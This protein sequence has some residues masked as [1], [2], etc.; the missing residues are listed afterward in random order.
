MTI[1][2]FIVFFLSGAAALV[3]QLVWQRA[4]FGI[5]GLD[6]A[7]V[8]VVVT[9]FMLG[10]GIGSLVGGALSHRHPKLTLPLFAC[11]ELGIGL[12]GFVS[13]P[14][15]DLVAG[16]TTGIGHAGTG[17]VAF[18]LLVFPTTLMGATLPLLVGH[19]TRGSQNVGRSVGNLYFVNTLGAAIGAFLAVEFL[20]SSLGLLASVKLMAVLNISLGVAVLAMDRMQSRVWEKTA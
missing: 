17:I 2:I 11:F 14:L 13:L 6:I 12:F 15:F 7:S 1:G 4:L 9:A 19:A 16:I 10:L 18:A 5:Y 20:L 3:Y 8:T